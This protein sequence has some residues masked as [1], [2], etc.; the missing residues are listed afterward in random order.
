MIGM[1]QCWS[2]QHTVVYSGYHYFSR[3][4]LKETHNYKIVRFWDNP[5]ITPT[6]TFTQQT[7]RNNRPKVCISGTEIQNEIKVELHHTKMSQARI[8]VALIT[9]LIVFEILPVVE[10]QNCSTMFSNTSRMIGHK[11]YFI[12]VIILYMNMFVYSVFNT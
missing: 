12:M 7:Q 5:A 9:V 1:Y 11:L 6:F 10:R 2:V 8:R 4:K 3:A